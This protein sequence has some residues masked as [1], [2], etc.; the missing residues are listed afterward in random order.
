MAVLSPEERLAYRMSIEKRM[1]KEMVLTKRDAE[2]HVVLPYDLFQ[3][4]MR[5][6]DQY[7]KHDG[8]EA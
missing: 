3:N 2:M 8:K 6:L 4:M 1:F 5:L 7:L